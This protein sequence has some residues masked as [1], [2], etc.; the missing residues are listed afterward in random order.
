MYFDEWYCNANHI[1]LDFL[2]Y[3]LFLQYFS[4]SLQ[5]I[6]PEPRKRHPI[7]NLDICANEER[8]YL[9][10]TEERGCIQMIMTHS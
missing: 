8:N 1:N 7:L 9:N 2:I 4:I 10:L 5:D 3:I 6:Q